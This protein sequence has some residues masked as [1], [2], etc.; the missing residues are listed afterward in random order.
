VAGAGFILVLRA[1]EIAVDR[2]AGTV[3]IM[4]LHQIIPQRQEQAVRDMVAVSEELCKDT[5]AAAVA[6]QGQPAEIVPIMDHYIIPKAVSVVLVYRTIFQGSILI[7]EAEA[8][9]QHIILP[10][11][12]LRLVAPG[13]AVMVRGIL[14]P[15]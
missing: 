1:R 3:S 13:A 2:G 5:V 10:V 11:H 6:V 15:V 7:T 14:L 9:D 12:L 8:E 4:M